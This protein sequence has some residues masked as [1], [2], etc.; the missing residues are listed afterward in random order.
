MAYVSLYR[1]YRP[2]SFADV[3]DQ[4]QVVHSLLGAL[5]KGRVVHAYLFAGPRG[6]GKTSVARILARAFNCL[7][8]K[9]FEPCNECA[10]CKGFLEGSALD[11]IEIDAASN[12]GI[13]E[14]RELR[15]K[16]KFAPS[17]SKYKVFIIDEAHMLT[18]EAFN[19]LLK[20]LEEPPEHAIFILATT[21]IHKIPA[22]ILS[23]CQRHSFRKIKVQDMVSYLQKVL[24][25]E[26]AAFDV[27]ALKIIAQ[28]SEGAMRDALSLTDQALSANG[29]VMLEDIEQLL[30]MGGKGEVV[31]FLT[32]LGQKQTREALELVAKIADGG[33]D[34]GEFAREV[35]F[36]L[37]QVLLIK[38]GS[39]TLLDDYTVDQVSAVEGIAKIYDADA[40]LRALKVFIEAE[41]Q[42]KNAYLPQLILEMAAT[43][44]AEGA[45]TVPESSVKPAEVAKS[46]PTVV[47]EKKETAAPKVADVAVAAEKVPDIKE[48]VS[49]FD[50]QKIKDH[51]GEILV[52][53]KPLNH[54]LNAILRSASVQIEG[55]K[56]YLGFPYKFHLERANEG[57]NMETLCRVIKEVTGNDWKVECKM[58]SAQEASVV[59][60]SGDVLVDTALEV[61]GGRKI[62]D[63]AV[64]GA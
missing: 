60:S 14:I 41:K 16:I 53:L 54:S 9:D 28:K 36:I 25:A 17:G 19:A 22:T 52:T 39:K 29:G 18:K 47:A 20:T 63:S 46:A 61:F 59:A 21:E 44:V 50:E 23:R 5:K 38:M 3:C 45:A 48:T 49:T 43:D 32:L 40:T 2:L 56:V 7:N 55:D 8:P 12:R 57:R 37:R 62:E 4:E 10:S 34:L 13:D 64:N 1:K 58:I 33:I 11:L 42:L 31:E 6:T 26:Q 27:E 30:G 35:V 51:W 24:S 15:D